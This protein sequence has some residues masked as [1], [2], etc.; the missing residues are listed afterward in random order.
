M[1]GCSH[2]SFPCRVSDISWGL[3]IPV[4]KVIVF[5]HPSIKHH[6][7]WVPDLKQWGRVVGLSQAWTPGLHQDNY[8]LSPLQAQAVQIWVLHIR[9]GCSWRRTKLV[10]PTIWWCCCSES[11]NVEGWFGV[12]DAEKAKNIFWEEFMSFVFT[13]RQ[14]EQLALHFLLFSALQQEC[15]NIYIWKHWNV[16]FQGDWNIMLILEVLCAYR[17][18]RTS[19]WNEKAQTRIFFMFFSRH[20]SV[21]RRHF[22]QRIQLQQNYF[23]WKAALSGWLQ[24]QGNTELGK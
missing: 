17:I 23:Q 2:F 24:R 4:Q 15:L 5:L 8:F 10:G 22:L 14:S 1:L 12:C 7:N 9:T 13:L 11:S 18:T 6:S 16:L 20:F 21:K 19:I 3:W